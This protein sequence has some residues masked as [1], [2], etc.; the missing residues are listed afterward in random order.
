MALVWPPLQVDVARRFRALPQRVRVGTPP[1]PDHFRL[2]LPKEEKALRRSS[3]EDPC[4]EPIIRRARLSRQYVL[5]QTASKHAPVATLHVWFERTSSTCAANSPEAEYAARMATEIRDAED[6]SQWDEV[7]ETTELMNEGRFVE[8]L[9]ALRTV[10]KRNPRNAYAYNFLGSALYETGQFDASRDAYRAALRLRPGYLGA[11]VSLSHVLR[12]LGDIN[13]AL[14]QANEALR[15]HPGD[16]D[17]LYAAALANAARGNRKTAKKQLEG[18][19]TTNP[20]FEA[21]L[22]VQQILGMLGLGD[23]NEPVEFE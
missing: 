17:A 23:S 19:L 14:S 6:A 9:V 11:R 5:G 15:Q 16:G 20:E 22:E 1:R 4:R 18:F 12:K 13:G 7:E 21:Q 8:A 10:I 2:L 3:D